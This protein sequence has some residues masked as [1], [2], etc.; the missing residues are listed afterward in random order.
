[1]VS[2]SN[3]VLADFYRM[4][5]SVLLLEL[6]EWYTS[7][8]PTSLT[9][10]YL[11]PSQHH[12]RRRWEVIKSVCTVSCRTQLI[13]FLGTFAKLCSAICA[14]EFSAHSLLLD[15]PQREWFCAC[16]QLDSGSISTVRHMIVYCISLTEKFRGVIDQ[17]Q[18]AHIRNVSF[19][20]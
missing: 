1:M 19:C 3:L 14:Y 4:T 18:S 12:C 5:E 9:L 10:W 16:V 7:V 6:F 15:S 11:Y 2:V 8:A 17:D 20:K 13:Q